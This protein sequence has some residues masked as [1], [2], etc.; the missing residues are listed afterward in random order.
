MSERVDPDNL[1]NTWI[2]DWYPG[3]GAQRPRETS[4]QGTSES[5]GPEDVQFSTDIPGGHEN[6]FFLD[7]GGDQNIVSDLANANDSWSSQTQP[8]IAPLHASMTDM[9]RETGYDGEHLDLEPSPRIS[10]FGAPYRTLDNGQGPIND[11]SHVDT[12]SVQSPT[13]ISHPSPWMSSEPWNPLRVSCGTPAEY[14]RPPFH[15]LGTSS[16]LLSTPTPSYGA[17]SSGS[18]ELTW[19]SNTSYRFKHPEITDNMN[20]VQK[21][22]IPEDLERSARRKSHAFGNSV[23]YTSHPM[24]VCNPPLTTNGHETCGVEGDTRPRCFERAL[25]SRNRYVKWRSK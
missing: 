21:P 24:I 10:R 3:Y 8:A 16:Q 25:H 15:G 17:G 19:T 11:I 5:Y 9:V 12:E 4:W 22:P 7:P 2:W 18:N 20:T 14:N 13:S 6:S 1:P 23:P